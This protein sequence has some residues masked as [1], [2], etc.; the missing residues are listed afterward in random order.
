MGRALWLGQ[1]RGPCAAATGWD[2]LRHFLSDPCTKLI[3]GH[4]GGSKNRILGIY[5]P[6]PHDLLNPC[7]KYEMHVQNCVQKSFIK[8]FCLMCETEGLSWPQRSAH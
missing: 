7:V 2:K 4:G 3:G 1:A 5:A 6:R 8:K